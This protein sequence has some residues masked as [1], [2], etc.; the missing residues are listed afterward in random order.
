MQMLSKSASGLSR[1]SP[2]TGRRSSVSIGNS[3]ATADHHMCMNSNA[4]QAALWA[5]VYCTLSPKKTD[6]SPNACLNRL[7]NERLKSSR[8]QLNPSTA[9]VC[10][11]SWQREQ[12]SGLDAK[13]HKT[14]TFDDERPIV[15]VKLEDKYLLVDGN[16]RVARWLSLAPTNRQYRVLLIRPQSRSPSDA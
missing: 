5:L 10:E 16:H 14:H 3:Q 11:E 1:F 4:E 7:T 2:A 13:H 6:H 9:F 8:V 12:L 15:V